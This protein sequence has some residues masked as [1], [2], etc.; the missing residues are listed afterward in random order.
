M[1]ICLDSLTNKLTISPALPVSQLCI[2]L[3]PCSGWR[4]DQE[5][6]GQGESQKFFTPSICYLLHLNATLVQNQSPACCS[7]S[8]K[9]AVGDNAW[10][11]H[12]LPCPVYHSSRRNTQS[13]SP[14]SLLRVLTYWKRV[15]IFGPGSA[16]CPTVASPRFRTLFLKTQACG[17]GSKS[18]PLAPC[19]LTRPH[20]THQGMREPLFVYD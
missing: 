2:S 6:P 3:Q 8:Q 9:C 15:V 12:G 1:W 20:E 14:E 17:D 16:G 7:R 13:P 11:V 10:H 18:M 19:R 4:Q 5:R